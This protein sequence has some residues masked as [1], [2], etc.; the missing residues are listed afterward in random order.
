MST[1]EERQARALAIET[2]FEAQKTDGKTMSRIEKAGSDILDELNDPSHKRLQAFIREVSI[3]NNPNK[4]M[5]R[6]ASTWL[7]STV[8][9]R[10]E[11]EK[12]TGVKQNSLKL[13][14]D[15][16]GKHA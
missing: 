4:V 15:Q 7:R 16:D 1:P 6:Y 11:I 3:E 13:V 14:S 8:G 10:A 12:M 2:A 9:L 5:Q